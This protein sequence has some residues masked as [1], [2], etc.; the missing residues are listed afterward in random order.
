MVLFVDGYHGK[1]KGTSLISWLHIMTKK[2]NKQLHLVAQ[3]DSRDATVVPSII[4]SA[5]KVEFVN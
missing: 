5:H 2:L 4:T 3:D 1:A